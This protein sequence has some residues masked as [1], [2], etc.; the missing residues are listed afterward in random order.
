MENHWLRHF[1]MMYVT[2][3]LPVLV[4]LTQWICPADCAAARRLLRQSEDEELDQ[5]A[6]PDASE[7]GAGRERLQTAAL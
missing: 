4:V 7:Q 6:A 3:C 5:Q 2:E 1:Q